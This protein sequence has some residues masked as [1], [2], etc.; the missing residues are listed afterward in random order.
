MSKP[1][2]RNYGG[3][4]QLRLDSTDEMAF[5][6]QLE[7]A[8]WSATSAPLSQF[9]CDPQLLK[10]VDTDGNGRIRVSEIRDA[11]KWLFDLLSNRDRVAK[12]SDE[13][14]ISAINAS[15]GDGAKMKALAEMMLRDLG[16]PGTGAI[17]LD[18]VRQFKATYASRFP[19]G[20]GIVPPEHAGGADLEALVKD[21]IATVGG[22]KDLGGNQGVRAEDVTTFVERTTRALAWEAEGNP[23]EKAGKQV[24]PAAL[25]WGP[26]TAAA[27]A[28]IEE[29]LPKVEQYFAQCDLL[30]LE[31]H[32]AGR[33]QA[34][35]E[36]LA[37]L[38]ITNTDALRKWA[39]N[40]P[41]APPRVDGLLDLG[42][43]I[44]PLYADSMG[45]LAMEVLPR[46]L[47]SIDK[48]YRLLSRADWARVR[49]LFAPY[50]DWQSRKPTDAPA[51]PSDRLKLI[52][53]SDQVTRLHDVLKRD[54][55]VADDLQQ[56]SNL[57]K[58]ILLQRWFKE[59]VNNFVSFPT[60][61]TPGERALFN[62]GS[63]VIDG[64]E[65]NFCVHVEDRGAHKKLA[66]TTPM[67]LL[68]AE[69]T[70]KGAASD[71]KREV[72][73]AV[74]SGM[75]GNLIIG[76]RGVFYDRDGN[77][78]DAIIVDLIENPISLYEAAISPFVR[79]GN[80][81]G[82]RIKKFAESKSSAAEASATEELTKKEEALKKAGDA[83]KTDKPADPAGSSNL[84]NMF[85]GLSLAFAAL[86]TALAMIFRAVVETPGTKL[87][88]GV[89]MLIL[90]IAGFSAFL[91]WLKLRKR[92]LSTILEACG[93]AMN[94]RMKLSRPLAL[95]FTRQPG[96]PSGAV[97]DKADM[98]ARSM[99]IKEGSGM[100]WVWIGLLLLGG[101]VGGYLYMHQDM[102]AEKG[103][104]PTLQT[105]PT[106]VQDLLK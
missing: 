58:L 2:F 80:F 48:P 98:L 16:A 24:H 91:G 11:Q 92:D 106:A 29:V 40:A 38:D 104:V 6:Q 90:T 30:K 76:K 57:E 93:W 23:V 14:Q 55:Q 25:P 101:L 71:Q 28:L 85:I 9:N 44:N 60:L 45:K 35:P 89:S 87:V 34:T 43:R 62:A 49:A 10:Y 21:I 20:D 54:Q 65:L 72:A 105:I 51:V 13:L 67:F 95:L 47:D 68:Y 46:A 56:W 73:C 33:M 103:I 94:L 17:S 8:R 41:L 59:L 99:G 52:T 22:A 83:P 27:S 3:M 86:S 12:A 88:A 26:E 39:V 36:V 74:T 66:E 102:L 64:R 78:W 19:N 75:R 81:V 50:R 15:S 1:V 42:G 82:E 97:R 100:R 84:S 5:I 31:Q 70:R 69:L 18:Q 53:T 96:L 63:L 32:A 4:Y 77:E 37:G 79:L 61:F 7:K